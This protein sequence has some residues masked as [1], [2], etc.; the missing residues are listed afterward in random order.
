MWSFLY[1]FY[2]VLGAMKK[3]LLMGSA[4]VGK[5]SMHKV[6]FADFLAKD[7]SKLVYTMPKEE[8]KITIMGNI[9]LN[10]WDCGFQNTFV[11]EYF[12]QKKD[13]IF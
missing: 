8:H 9:E 7:T 10:V 6:I 3:M 12:N 1:F 4:G 2:I 11:E 5:T 13:L